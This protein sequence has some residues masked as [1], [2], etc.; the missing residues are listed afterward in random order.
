MAEYNIEVQVN[1]RPALRGMDRVKRGLTDVDRAADNVGKTFQRVFAGLSV[2]FAIQ[3]LVQYSDAF[4][5]IQNGLR[6][7]GLAQADLN[8]VTAQTFKIAND[9]LQ[10]VEAIG[11]LYRRASLAANEL[12]ASQE[13]LAQFTETVGNALRIQGSSAGAASGAL[14][15]LSQALGSGVV[16]AEEFNSIL[17]GAFPLAQAAAKGID[18]TGGS[19]ARLRNLIITGQISSEEFFNGILSQS[20]ELEKQ[21]ENAVVTIGQSFTVLNNNIIEYIG[22]ISTSSG[23]TQAAANTILLLAN[24]LDIVA[25]AAQTLAVTLGVALA[26]KAIPAVIAGVGALTAV[27]AANPFGALAIGITAAISALFAFSDKI[28]GA[29]QVVNELT[30]AVLAVVDVTV[31]GFLSLVNS[32]SPFEITL[33]DVGNAFVLLGQVAQGIISAIIFSFDFLRASAIAV[34]A[35]IADP[36]NAATAAT[37]AFQENIGKAGGAFQK[38]FDARQSGRVREE[39]KNQIKETQAALEAEA[40]AAEAASLKIDKAT[41]RRSDL[42]NSILGPIDQAKTK[43]ADLDILFK[44][45]SLTLEQYEKARKPLVNTI[46]ST[47]SATTQ[48]TAS[49]QSEIDKLKVSNELLQV[50]GL[51]REALNN[52]LSVQDALKRQL[53]ETEKAEIVELTKTNSLLERQ[54][55]I[56]ESIKGPPEKARQDMEALEALFA[57]GQITTAEYNKEYNK[58]AAQLASF[59]PSPQGG[60]D[61]YFANLEANALTAADTMRMAFEATT[62]AMSTFFEDFANTGKLN[63][64]SLAD[65]I[66]KQINRIAAQALSQQFAGLFKGLG[67]GGGG[68]FGGLFGGGGGGGGG[69][70]GG[71]LPGFATGG[72]FSI[73]GLNG[74]DNNILSLNNK[75]I[76]R[77]SK[78]E[79]VNI[80]NNGSG[81]TPVQVIMNVSTP[82]AGSFKES[83]GQILARTA[84]ALNRAQQRNR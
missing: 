17:E 53:T 34:G 58:F 50:Q 43:L 23:I 75:P 82:D 20:E 19:V 80:D 21:L 48:A 69:L 47:T 32:V 60:I 51:E 71:I 59:D 7:T 64:K 2:A 81:R 11:T 40:N 74:I 78:G 56:L 72:S 35:A 9:T 24:N 84:T 67:S 44:Q 46:N 54:S 3:Q 42:L 1:P 39:L 36:L 68:L 5:G 79:T 63:F 77:V 10:P 38:A 4:I 13:Q 73:G 25:A 55:Q 8:R 26:A 6:A 27:I 18:R 22:N 49:F 62:G 70:F 57:S 45:G 31:A 33:E 14:L 28:E 41:I 76:A 52:I 15:Q 83:Q 61:Q 37:A 66:L 29:N 65:D 16:R 12:G 30:D